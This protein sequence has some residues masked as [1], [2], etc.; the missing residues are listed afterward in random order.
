MGQRAVRP[1]PVGGAMGAER[2]SM[3]Q[4]REILRQKCTL[5]GSHREVAGPLGA[6]LGTISGVERRASA[7]GGGP[8]DLG[9]ASPRA[10]ASGN[11]GINDQEPESVVEFASQACRPEAD[12][13]L[14][15]CT[16]GDPSRP[17]PQS[18]RGSASRW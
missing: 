15:S 4:I 10:A 17:S 6:G 8:A 1:E 12:T 7:A 11:Q 3:R 5:G 9:P 18:R 13:L 2:L 16:R 14:C